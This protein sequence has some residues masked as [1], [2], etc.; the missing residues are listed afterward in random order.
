MTINRT[1]FYKLVG[2]VYE[3]YEQDQSS[4]Q[5]THSDNGWRLRSRKYGARSTFSNLPLR[6]RLLARP[7]PLEQNQSGVYILRDSIFPN[8]FYISGSSDISDR[9]WK[10][11]VKL[12]GTEFWNPGVQDTGNFSEYRKL[13]LDKGLTTFDDIEIAFW[14][15]DNHK[16]LTTA[17]LIAYESKY[18]NLPFCN[19]TYNI[20]KFGMFE[21]WDI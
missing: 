14:F 10:H 20:V 3:H 1:K 19:G 7:C 5:R 15:T 18:S 2:D 13:R 16:S 12:D 11:G 9:I 17:L 8:G 4:S 21:P 6:D